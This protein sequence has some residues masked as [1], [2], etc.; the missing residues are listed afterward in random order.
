MG[1]ADEVR[2]TSAAPPEGDL[3]QQLGREFRAK[4]AARAGTARS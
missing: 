3:G 2:A 4:F 1:D